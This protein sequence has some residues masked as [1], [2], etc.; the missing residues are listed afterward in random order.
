LFLSCA[1]KVE[2]EED[3]TSVHESSLETEG[4]I[5]KCNSFSDKTF[6]GQVELAQPGCINMTILEYPQNMFNKETVFVQAYP[7]VLENDRLN[8]GSSLTIDIHDIDSEKFVFQTKLIDAYL[9][10]EEIQFD[11]IESFFQKNYFQFCDIG[12]WDALKLVVYLR[13]EEHS[14]GILRE[15]SFLIPPFLANPNHFR[16]ERGEGLFPY[17]PFFKVKNS[18]QIEPSSYYTLSQS[19][20]SFEL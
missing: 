19:L 16:Q 5:L 10:Q 14:P 17:H 8:Y 11:S 15:T 7:F 4:R 12:D 6:R 2:Y 13:Q 1:V 20:C 3:F 9:I 18:L